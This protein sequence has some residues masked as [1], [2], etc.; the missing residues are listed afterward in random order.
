MIKIGEQVEALIF[1]YVGVAHIY[2]I[3]QWNGEEILHKC[4][5]LKKGSWFGDY[6]ILTQTQ[7]AW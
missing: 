7:S 6:Q 4:I 1:I 3:S 5:T 2:G